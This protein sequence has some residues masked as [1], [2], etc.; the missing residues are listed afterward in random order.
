MGKDWG[1]Q[2]GVGILKIEFQNVK[3]V[4]DVYLSTSYIGKT[5]TEKS[6]LSYEDSND[7]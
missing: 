3:V 6:E 5:Q 2:N 7:L 4:Q 1:L